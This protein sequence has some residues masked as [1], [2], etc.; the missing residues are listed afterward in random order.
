MDVILLISSI[1]SLVTGV[2]GY[3]AG[4]FTKNGRKKLK[5][6]ADKA[7]VDGFEERIRSLNQIMKIHNETMTEQSQQIKSLNHA[8]YEKTELI[9]SLNQKIWDAEQEINSVNSQLVDAQ[10]EIADLRVRCEKFHSWHCRHAEC[11]NRIP[12]NPVLIGQKYE[13]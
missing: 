5:A 2:G 12:P 8:L 6:E 7:V 11:P 3:F 9:R 4:S 1:G 10:K 13:D